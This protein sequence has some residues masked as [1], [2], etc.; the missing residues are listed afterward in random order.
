MEWWNYPEEACDSENLIFTNWSW[1]RVAQWWEH[2]P[3]ANVAQVW[4]LVLMPYVGWVCCWF[5]PLLQEVFLQVLRFSPLLKNQHFQ[6]PI[7]SGTHRHVSTSSWELLTAPWVNNL[8]WQYKSHEHSLSW[9]KMEIGQ[10]AL[11]RL[12][13]STEFLHSLP[14]KHL[15]INL[16][17]LMQTSHQITDYIG[18][19][20][21]DK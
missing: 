15:A 12:C 1:A 17:L 4:I 7:Q 11:T 16:P 10:L 18:V 19:K 6:V 13:F 3:T 5:S 14:H 21:W 20:T 8:Q 2:S 9:L